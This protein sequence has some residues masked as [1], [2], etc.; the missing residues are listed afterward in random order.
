M[1]LCHGKKLAY[2]LIVNPLQLPP[3]IYI[4]HL[5]EFDY[6]LTLLFSPEEK[7]KG[8]TL[9]MANAVWTDIKLESK[10]QS[11]KT[12]RGKPLILEVF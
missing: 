1:H 8:L 10:G 12:E 3:A 9:D 4:L 2:L 7:G 6:F 5:V 11:T